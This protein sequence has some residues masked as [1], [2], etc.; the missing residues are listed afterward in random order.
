MIWNTAAKILVKND[1]I[2]SIKIG[3]YKRMLKNC[4]LEVQ[5]MYDDI[6]WYPNNF[7]IETAIHA[8]N[9]SYN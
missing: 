7:K 4:L 5:N 1:D 6:E 3:P 2:L 9:L 8:D